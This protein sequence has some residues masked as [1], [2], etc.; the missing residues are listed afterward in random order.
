MLKVTV[1]QEMQKL[2]DKVAIN[3]NLRNVKLP[4]KIKSLFKTALEISPKHHILMQ[5]E[6]QK[7]TDNAVSKT[8]N[9]PKNASEK[10]VKEAYLL[11]YE[12]K[13]KGITI[14]RYNSK[15]QQVL[16]IGKGKKISH[17]TIEF[18]GGTCIGK[19]CSF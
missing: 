13:C 14:Y 5:A 10:E 1:K 8:I 19:V 6:F 2:M 12:K 16:Y 9:L 17:A 4:R 18:S 3:G 15:P 11:A 7:H